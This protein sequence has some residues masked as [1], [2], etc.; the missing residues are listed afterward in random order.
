MDLMSHADTKLMTNLQ[1]V[2]RIIDAISKLP[3]NIWVAEYIADDWAICI[4]TQV[5]DVQVRIIYLGQIHMFLQD[6]KLGKF[7]AD[8][9]L[10]H[11]ALLENVW[12][13]VRNHRYREVLDLAHSGLG[14]PDPH[15]PYLDL[16][17]EVYDYASD[18]IKWPKKLSSKVEAVLKRN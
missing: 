8:L 16:L 12:R 13:Q 6:P 3:S 14:D 1:V 17:R 2:G 18:H 11:R 10:T 4:G 5:G 15:P 7:E 9:T